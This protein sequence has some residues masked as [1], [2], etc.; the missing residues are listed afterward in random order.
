MKLQA[1][2]KFNNR[3]ALAFDEKIKLTYR[4]LDK[5]IYGTDGTFYSC[6]YYEKPFGAFHAFGGSK[7]NI[8]LESGEVVECCGQWWDGGYDALS[9]ILGI[10]LVH[11][12]AKDIDSLKDCYVYS[13]YHADKSKLDEI[14]SSHDGPVFPY[15]D[16]EKL[17]K[18]DD[19]RSEFF[20]YKWKSER[21]KKKLIAN[22]RLY[23][24]MLKA[25]K[26]G[27]TGIKEW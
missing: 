16:Y 4:R 25:I 13:G 3:V 26:K 7:F 17:I 8:H 24:G 27:I 21:A 6:Y 2:V 22:V 1:L 10:E 15:F 9:K 5:F 14:I 12:T 18:Y 20:N 19:L 23:Y 11:A